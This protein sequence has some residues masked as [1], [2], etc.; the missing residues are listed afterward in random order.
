VEF[1]DDGVTP[2]VTQSY[3][4]TASVDT[5]DTIGAGH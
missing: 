5:T 1:A 3:T 2:V 4:T